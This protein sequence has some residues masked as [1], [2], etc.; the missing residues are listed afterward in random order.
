MESHSTNVNGY[1]PCTCA[2]ATDVLIL[3]KELDY[4]R[5][6]YER[7]RE[8][9]KEFQQYSKELESE[10]DIELKQRDSKMNELEAARRRLNSELGELKARIQQQLQDHLKSE[11]HF[12]SIVSTAEQHCIELRQKLRAVEQTNDDLERRERIHAQQLI[13]LG[14]RYEKCL[15]R[16]AMFEVGMATESSRIVMDDAEMNNSTVPTSPGIENQQIDRNE[17]QRLIENMLIKIEAIESAILSTSS[18]TV[19]PSVNG[20]HHSNGNFHHNQHNGR[21]NN[22][23]GGKH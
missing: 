16:C 20:C 17:S 8:Q 11:E 18:G 19:S 21:L 2:A 5:S 6:M 3:R 22:D 13:D 14:D 15:E 12:K 1:Q 4:Y 7:E 9:F 23:L 10:M